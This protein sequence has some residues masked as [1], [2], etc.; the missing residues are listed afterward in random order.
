MESSP[1]AFEFARP[2]TA[3]ERGRLRLSVDAEAADALLQQLPASLRPQVVVALLA[4]PR[5]DEAL[6][7]IELVRPDDPTVGAP[8]AS[9]VVAFGAV[10]VILSFGD[11][12]LDALF[13]RAAG[14]EA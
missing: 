13:R 2:L 9:G 11:P 8:A 14:R 10:P 5:L 6:A 7:A 12:E 1:P 4:E 3:D